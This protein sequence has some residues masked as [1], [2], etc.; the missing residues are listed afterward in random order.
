MLRDAKYNSVRDPAPRRCSAVSAGTGGIG[1]HRSAHRRRSGV[2]DERRPRSRAQSGAEPADDG[3]VD[4]ARAGGAP[5]RAGEDLRAGLHAVRRAG[6]AGG[7]DRAVRPD[8]VR[9]G[10]ADERDRHPHGARRTARRR[11]APGAA[12]RS[13]ILVA[14]GVA[15]GVAGLARRRPLR[16]DAALRPGA[17][18]HADDR[19][20]D[21]PDDRRLG[22]GRLPAGAPRVEG[23]SD[24]GSQIRSRSR[25]SLERPRVERRARSAGASDFGRRQSATAIRPGPQL[26]RALPS[27][28]CELRERARCL[29]LKDRRLNENRERLRVHPAGQMVSTRV[30]E[31][32][33]A[34]RAFSY[35][36]E[37]GFQHGSDLEDWLRAE[38]ELTALK[39]PARR[40]AAPDDLYSPVAPSGPSPHN[41][42]RLSPPTGC[43]PGAARSANGRGTCL[44][45]S[46]GEGAESHGVAAPMT[47][48]VTWAV[49]PT[50][51]M[52]AEGQLLPEQGHIPSVRADTPLSP[53]DTCGVHPGS[54][55]HP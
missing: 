52:K 36:C 34:A 55:R 54:R 1:G 47:T 38:R 20:S 15:I 2:G 39:K 23:R 51:I 40:R 10:A 4:T 5:L 43:R 26:A 41:C 50:K 17:H 25:L 21:R 7:L 18:R 53:A 16:L 31:S 14:I 24:G 11:D 45:V 30:S 22:A 13:M 35:Y 8:V 27:A 46:Q 28:P 37:R 48:C 44:A 12:S 6:A 9:G 49:R 32:D 33:I 29:L 42:R 3:R 19:R